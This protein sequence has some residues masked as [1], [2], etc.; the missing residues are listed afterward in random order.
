MRGRRRTGLRVRPRQ[1]TNCRST[2][3]RSGVRRAAAAPGAGE[4]AAA[5]TER[6]RQAKICERARDAAVKWKRVEG[7][8]G[9]TTA[10]WAE[11]TSVVRACGR[12]GL[13]R[14]R[15]QASRELEL[16]AAEGHC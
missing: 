7:R 5:V 10:A 12:N 15:R 3:R 9:A 16:A 2:T 4:A 6:F 8:V 14:A 11:L 13:G 1:Q